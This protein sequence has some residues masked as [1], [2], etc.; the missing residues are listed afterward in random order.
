MRSLH[1]AVG[2]FTVFKVPSFDID[3]TT[4]RRALRA[5]PWVGLL[6]GFVAGAFGQVVGG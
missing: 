6:L 4:A 3:R 5:L 2:L 1:A